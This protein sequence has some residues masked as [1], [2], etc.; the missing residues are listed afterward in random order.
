MRAGVASTR[1]LSGSYCSSP[2]PYLRPK[3]PWERREPKRTVL[4]RATRPWLRIRDGRRNAP[5]DRYTNA[6][7]FPGPY[8]H[9]GLP[10]RRG[11]P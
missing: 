5:A 9:Q 11:Y 10:T 4:T 7:R 3:W 8:M 1:L 2:A 6:G